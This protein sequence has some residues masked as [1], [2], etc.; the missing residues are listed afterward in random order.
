MNP[1]GFG[2]E[3]T[4]GSTSSI[5]S[6]STTGS[7]WSWIALV[8]PCCCR[9]CGRVEPGDGW[10]AHPSLPGPSWG[11]VLVHEPRLPRP[12]LR[13]PEPGPARPSRRLRL[14]EDA[15]LCSATQCCRF[16]WVSCYV[17]YF[18]FV[19]F[20][21]EFYFLPRHYACESSLFGILNHQLLNKQNISLIFK[22]QF[23]FFYPWKKSLSDVIRYT[24]T[25][26]IYFYFCNVYDVDSLSL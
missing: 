1:S 12:S 11:P 3:W 17:T 10:R 14:L 15:M 26:F 18:H 8:S 24:L 23:V 13:Q 6:N 25:L 5:D 22:E 21:S 9:Q 19:R 20:W 4:T 2:F 7:D 16:Y